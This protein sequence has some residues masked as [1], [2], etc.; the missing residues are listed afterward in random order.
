MRPYSHLS[1]HYQAADRLSPTPP[2]ASA[3]SVELPTST[4]ESSPIANSTTEDSSDVAEV[5]TTSATADVPVMNGHVHG[6]SSDTGNVTE[7]CIDGT[8]EQAGATAEPSGEELTQD[9]GDY[10]KDEEAKGSEEDSDEDLR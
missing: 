5:P 4:T 10:D 6:D 7:D 2:S 9:T 1:I 3:T 8:S